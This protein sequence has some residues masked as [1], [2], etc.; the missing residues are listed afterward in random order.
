MRSIVRY[1]RRFAAPG[2]VRLRCDMTHWFRPLEITISS[3]IRMTGSGAVN[4]SLQS[5]LGKAGTGCSLK[6]LQTTI[7][8]VFGVKVIPMASGRFF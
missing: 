7:I 5:P 2:Y 4:W 8:S 3:F 1:G 6:E